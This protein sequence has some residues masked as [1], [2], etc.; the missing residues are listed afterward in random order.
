[1][2]QRRTGWIKPPVRSLFALLLLVPALAGA[3]TPEQ[4]LRR[5]SL[6]QA[7]A[8]AWKDPYWLKLLYYEK[9]LTGGYHSPSVNP[10]FFLA[11]WGRISPRLE[12]EAAVDG[13]FFEGKD[14][15]AG[16][17]CRFPERYRWLRGKLG[18]TPAEFPPPACADFEDWKAGLDAESVS[19]LFAA[20]YLNNP[21]T[22]YGHTFLRLHKRGAAGADLLDYTIN[23]AATADA[24][25]G[26][27]FALKGLV[28][29]YPGQ[30]STIPYYLKIQ[31]YHNIENRDLWEFPLNLKPEEIDR[32]LRHGWELGKASFPYLFFTR[33]C[34][35]QLLPLLDIV[36]P[37]LYLSRRFHIWVI[38]SDTAKA[39]IAASPPATPGWR[40][41]LWKNVDWKRSQLSEG[42]KASVLKLARGD[43]GAELKRLQAANPVSQAA[44]LE[45]AVDYLSWRFY[46]RR[47]GK[48]ELDNR[49]DPLLAARA[50]LGRQL[51]F[52]GGPARPESVTA[53]HESLR[54]GAG[55]VSLR[56]G[57]AYELQGRFAL[58]DLLD[59]PA[60]YLPDAALEMGG[61]R[62]RYDKSYNRLYFKEG[63]LA[64]VISLNPWD[65][66]VRRPSWEI[67]A[68][69]EQADETGRQSGRAAVWAMNAG[70]GLALEFKGPVRQLWY[71][72]AE[73]DS[74]FG[75][76]LDANWRAGA[77]LKA[78]LL[79]ERG[80]FRLLAEAR[81]ISYALGDSRPLWAGSA[82][83]SFRLQRNTS[84]RLE[85]SWRGKVKE[86]G[87]YFHQFVFPP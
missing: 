50:P 82:A 2:T 63:R 66:W 45:T 55:L 44:V 60:G 23:Y 24:E 5:L 61:L 70:S 54:L 77:G 29:A 57:P 42:E 83:A 19:L 31:E 86:A 25:S 16:P 62:L 39:V 58:Q 49:T 73:A 26:I 48:T 79:A 76:A 33:N 64:R 87:L 53:G 65:G 84:A 4:E 22:L 17:E 75:P 40:P 9:S 46:A 14:A 3:V 51:T 74:A 38:P 71:L 67:N 21:S 80:A 11:K 10:N 36:K 47:I 59:D 43:Q 81:Y 8:E 6:R 69:F 13:L 12:L 32:L 78:G 15:N 27:F 18:L 37:G 56:H 85:Y 34:S 20:G 68:G 52:T 28:G 35:W 72:L 7:S 1:M 41:S 30:F